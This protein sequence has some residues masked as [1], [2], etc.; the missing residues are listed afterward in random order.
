MNDFSFNEKNSFRPIKLMLCGF[1]PEYREMLSLL[2]SGEAILCDSDAQVIIAQEGAE[3]N[4]PNIPT[5]ILGTTDTRR[6]NKIYIKRPVDLRKLKAAVL[7]MARSDIHTSESANGLTC[8]S[9]TLTVSLGK[10][11][12]QLTS[13]EFALFYLLYEHMG[14]TVSREDINSTLWQEGE[15]SNVCDVYICYLRKKLDPLIGKGNILSVRGQGYM[16][17]KIGG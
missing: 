13:L 7:S 1:S 16:L 9:E 10:N 6:R 11:T 8:D 5:F 15:G 2:F 12:V 3:I 17:R 14:A 4:R